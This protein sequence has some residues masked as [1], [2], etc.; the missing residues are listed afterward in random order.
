MFRT[1]IASLSVS[2]I[3]VVKGFFSLKAETTL[4]IDEKDVLAGRIEK[5]ISTSAFSDD[6][7]A[8]GED[9]IKWMAEP[10]TDQETREKNADSMRVKMESMVMRIQ[11]EFCRALEGQENPK[12][13]F[14]VKHKTTLCD[15]VPR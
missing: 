15:I 11:K 12:Y 7:T 5:I 10:L 9:G 3:S 2:G 8:D 1:A 14:K 4:G 6:E 13:K